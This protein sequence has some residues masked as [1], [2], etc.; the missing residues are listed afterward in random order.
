MVIAIAAAVGGI[1]YFTRSSPA[2]VAN[3]DVNQGLA[4]QAAG[5]MDTAAADYQEALKRDPRNKYAYFDLGVISGIQNNGAQAESYYRQ[6]IGI[7]PAFTGPLFNLA[8]LRTA[9]GDTAEAESLYRKVIA[10]NPRDA[11]AHLNLGFLLIQLNRRPEAI[12]EFNLATQITPTLASR[13]PPAD[14]TTN[15]PPAAPGKS[16]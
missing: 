5:Q 1:I 7:D 10:A 4:A 2:D 15:P 8:I 16:G 9:D 11:N 12:S 3:A 6:A 13:I 14:L